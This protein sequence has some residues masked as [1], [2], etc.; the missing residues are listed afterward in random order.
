MHIFIFDFAV[1]QVIGALWLLPVAYY[2]VVSGCELQRILYENYPWVRLPETS[3][4]T[5]VVR[6]YAQLQFIPHI[7]GGMGT[8]KRDR[9]SGSKSPR[10]SVSRDGN[11]ID[12]C[13]RLWTV[14]FAAY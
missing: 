9:S 7:F 13:F 2:S 12:T 10:C 11:L 6:Y 4:A 3:T 1:I 8:Q 5:L 14:A